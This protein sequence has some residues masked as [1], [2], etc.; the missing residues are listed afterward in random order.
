MCLGPPGR[1]GAIKCQQ[2][3]NFYF[4]QFFFFFFLQ[5]L[6]G[7]LVEENRKDFL[8]KAHI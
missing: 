7:K 4:Y 1:K 2:L 5:F 6:K 8:C 3:H